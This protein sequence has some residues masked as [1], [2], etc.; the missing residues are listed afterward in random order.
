MSNRCTLLH[1]TQLL[2]YLVLTVSNSTSD[3]IPLTL[4]A[5]KG[6]HLMKKP[7]F[8]TWGL[9]V[10]ALIHSDQLGFGHITGL[11]RAHIS[12]DLPVH[13]LTDMYVLKYL[14]ETFHEQGMGVTEWTNAVHPGFPYVST[15][16][17]PKI[18]CRVA[19]RYLTAHLSHYS[20]KIAYEQSH[21]YPK[22]EGMKDGQYTEMRGEAANLMLRDLRE[23]CT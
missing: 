11:M 19:T 10:P 7:G 8:K 1:R 18:D 2:V 3:N 13:H 9:H 17:G 4:T 12:S 23:H 14:I 16:N 15:R 20:S 5:E 22:I 21:R 6:R